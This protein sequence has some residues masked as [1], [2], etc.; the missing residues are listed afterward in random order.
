[1]VDVQAAPAPPIDE[2]VSDSMVGSDNVVPATSHRAP[3]KGVV[4]R[5]TRQ[6][7]GK[8]PTSQ[9]TTQSVEVQKRKGK[10]TRSV[11][12]V[13]TTT[14]SSDVE[15]NDVDDGEGDVESTRATMAPSPGKQVVEM[16]R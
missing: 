9:A 14:I 1:V 12:S 6:T 4:S 2:Y 5:R 11:V 8:I 3:S 10:R 16:P 7:A 13:D 15:T